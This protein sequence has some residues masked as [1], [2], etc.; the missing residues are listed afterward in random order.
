MQQICAKK[1]VRAREFLSVEQLKAIPSGCG[2]W[3]LLCLLSTERKL[4]LMKA[5]KI[6]NSNF[7][8]CQP[9]MNKLIFFRPTKPELLPCQAAEHTAQKKVLKLFKH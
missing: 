5:Q 2:A 4:L 9:E 3:L 6:L 7:R 1:F 8:D